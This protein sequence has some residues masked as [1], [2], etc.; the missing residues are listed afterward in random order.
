MIVK[1]VAGGGGRG[2]RVVTSADELEA[3]YERCRSEAQAAVR[4]AGRVR[5]GVPSARPACRGADPRRPARRR[6]PPRR[7]RVQRPAPPPE[8]GG[9]RAGAGAVRR[10]A[11]RDHRR[12]RTLRRKRAVHQS[13]DVRVPGGRLGGPSGATLRVHRDQCPP[14]GGAHGD[15]G[16]DRRG[17]RADPAPARRRGFPRRPGAWRRGGPRAAGLRDPGAGQHGDDRRGRDGASGKRHAGRSTRRRAARACARTASGTPVTRTSTAFDSLLAKVVGYSP[18]T[19]FAAAIGRTS[20]AL[21]EFR[22]EGVG[23]NLPFLRNVL[24]HEDFAAARVYTRWV[25][26]HLAELAVP[27]ADSAHRFVGA[28]T[29]A[30]DGGQGGYAGARVDSSDPL[31][32]F[33]HDARVKAGPGRPPRS[34]RSCPTWWVPR[35]P[36]GSARRSRARS[37]RWTWTVDDEVRKGPAGG[38]GRGHEDGARHRRG[39]RRR[40]TAH[41][42]GRR[43]RRPRGLSDRVRRGGRGHGRHA[44]PRSRRSIRTTSVRTCGRPT[45]A[46]T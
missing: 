4:R 33:D 37:S 46:T 6:R 7:A 31:A 21:S 22:L 30:A 15:G 42:D 12:G 18:S 20:R 2:T 29:D 8:A 9:G 32:L 43:R 11:R 39:P 10:A 35:A 5:R 45:S 28:G 27:E 23:T 36:S 13:R 17:P 25:D 14:A 1:A 40:R 38:G 34:R 24:R 3:A 44:P 41:H 16:G 19:D 26:E